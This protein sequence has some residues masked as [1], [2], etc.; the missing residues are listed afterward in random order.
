MPTTYEVLSTCYGWAMNK[1]RLFD[2][3]GF[4]FLVAVVLSAILFV[5]LGLLSLAGRV[6]YW[7]LASPVVCGISYFIAFVVLGV[8]GFIRSRDLDL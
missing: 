8:Y 3:I 1:S 6:A 2:R 7:I 4:A 5:G